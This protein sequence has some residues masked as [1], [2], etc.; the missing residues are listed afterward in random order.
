M[1]GDC[2]VCG[3]T[4]DGLV[5]CHNPHCANLVCSG[6]RVESDHGY[7]CRECEK[8]VREVS[9]RWE[10]KKKIR[11]SMLPPWDE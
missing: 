7:L 2:D 1:E 11:D 3:Q 8:K 9:T 6:C 4:S 5:E 10:G